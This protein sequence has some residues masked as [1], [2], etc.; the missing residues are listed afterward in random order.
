MLKPRPATSKLPVKRRDWRCRAYIKLSEELS[1]RAAETRWGTDKE[2][3][4]IKRMRTYTEHHG[5]AALTNCYI[6]PKKKA[7]SSRGL[8]AA[9]SKRAKARKSKK[10]DA[11]VKN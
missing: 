9:G 6:P 4:E 2:Y 3:R 11:D 5:L 1:R 10:S 8:L 7:G